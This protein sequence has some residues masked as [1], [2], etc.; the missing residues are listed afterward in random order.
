MNGNVCF[1]T[2][3]NHADDNDD[4]DDNDSDDCSKIKWYFLKVFT[5]EF[6]QPNSSISIKRMP[7]NEI[8]IIVWAHVQRT[9]RSFVRYPHLEIWTAPIQKK[10]CLTVLYDGY[11]AVSGKYIQMHM[12]RGCVWVCMVLPVSLCLVFITPFGNKHTRTFHFI[13]IVVYTLAFK[14]S[15][16]QNFINFL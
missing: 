5:R 12:F 4:D 1:T 14:H 7:L 2:H 8:V 6:Y 9:Q 3:K 10:H 13:L 11:G 15:F 16:S